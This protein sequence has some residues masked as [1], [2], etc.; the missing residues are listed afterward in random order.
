LENP[1]IFF[2][3]NSR[4]NLHPETSNYEESKKNEIKLE[5]PCQSSWVG[6]NEE[7]RKSKNSDI[8]GINLVE[9]FVEFEMNKGE[10]MVSF[11]EEAQ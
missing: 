4:T 9:F 8:I 7:Q 10:I 3:Q 11:D 1:Q 6:E 5:V 2:Y